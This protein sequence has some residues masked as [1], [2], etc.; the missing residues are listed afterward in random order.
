ML[1]LDKYVVLG[2]LDRRTGGQGVVQFMRS[3]KDGQNYAAKVCAWPVPTI[4]RIVNCVQRCRIY[5]H[6]CCIA[7][8]VTWTNSTSC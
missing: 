4:L 2:A 3:C 6:M 5:T 1:F 8:C 7:S